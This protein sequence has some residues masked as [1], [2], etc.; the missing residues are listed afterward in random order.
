MT[1]R[2]PYPFRVFLLFTAFTN[3]DF[4]WTSFLDGVVPAGRS[5]SYAGMVA[6][7]GGALLLVLLL[8]LLL[9]GRSVYSTWQ[10]SHAG[11]KWRQHARVSLR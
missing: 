2:W 11:N 5:L 6:I 8:T 1:S 3:W 9:G 4:A 7:A 10:A